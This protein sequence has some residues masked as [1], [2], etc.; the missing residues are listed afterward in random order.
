MFNRPLTVTGAYLF[1]E[2]IEDGNFYPAEVFFHQM[3]LDRVDESTDE[4]V[5][6]N[7]DFD[8]D[9]PVLRIPKTRAYYVTGDVMLKNSFGPGEYDPGHVNERFGNTMQPKTWYL[10]PQAYS[11]ILTPEI[12][13]SSSDS[14]DSLDKYLSILFFYKTNFSIFYV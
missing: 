1:P 8:L 5:V 12:V 13:S 11:I 2:E 14:S 3:V 9:V 4:Y 7:T 6:Q 10:L